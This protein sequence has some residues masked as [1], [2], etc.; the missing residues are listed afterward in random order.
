[1]LQVTITK[2]HHAFCEIKHI[3]VRNNLAETDRLTFEYLRIAGFSNCPRGTS[4]VNDSRLLRR[5]IVFEP[6][7]RKVQ[8]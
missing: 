8:L 3:D 4:A 5:I 7:H 2:I 1:M 6:N